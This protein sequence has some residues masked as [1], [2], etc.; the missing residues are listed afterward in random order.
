MMKS[1][2]FH[3][4][5]GLRK[6]CADEEDESLSTTIFDRFIAS[7]NNT[8][9]VFLSSSLNNLLIRLT[10]DVQLESIDKMYVI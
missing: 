4:K 1:S 2:K 5:T 3:K 7:V 10:K 6:V 9:K 8:N